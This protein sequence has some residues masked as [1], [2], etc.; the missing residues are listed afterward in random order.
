MNFEKIILSKIWKIHFWGLPEYKDVLRIWPSL[1]IVTFATYDMS[2]TFMINALFSIKN[3]G[4][5]MSEMN[6]SLDH[7]FRITL[8]SF[9][10]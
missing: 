1:W 9:P 2:Q 8:K 7:P 5:C 6:P 3:R 4:S 10:S